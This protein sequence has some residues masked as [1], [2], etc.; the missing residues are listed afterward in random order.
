M[1]NDTQK[2]FSVLDIAK[3]IIN[4]CLYAGTPVS[5]LQLQ[6]I[7]YLIQIEWIKQR[8]EI[9]FNSRMVAW[10]NG[11]MIPVI[12]NVYCGYGS[13]KILS[14][15]DVNIPE[16]ITKTIDLIIEKC[17]AAP[18]GDIQK[19]ICQ[20]GSPWDFIYCNGRGSHCEI[21]FDIIY[22]YCLGKNLKYERVNNNS[23]NLSKTLVVNLFGVP[24]S[25][26]STGAAYIFSQLK[27][28]GVNC[29]LITEYAK[30][31]VW[32]EN[33]IA[34]S[35][36]IYVFAKQYYRMDCVNGKVDVIITDSPLAL[37]VFYNKSNVLG[38]AFN[39]TVL[40]VFNSFKN[41][42]YFI[43]RSAPYQKEGRLQ[44]EVES[45]AMVAPMINILDSNG[46]IYEDIRGNQEDYDKVVQSV[47]YRVKK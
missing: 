5:N 47:L 25:G 1:G 33:N 15:Y 38:E 21:P 10:Q 7:L 17:I 45:K 36:Q 46:I 3:Y 35:N 8:G 32:E 13:G 42:N 18:F 29:E 11:V 9:L 20:K 30:D 27:M 37:S 12:Y 16:Y 14:I 40:N 4:K 19:M 24:D 43:C 41:L 39:Q 31:K 28:N 44:S 23:E 34:L 6:E 26:K 22:K 2:P